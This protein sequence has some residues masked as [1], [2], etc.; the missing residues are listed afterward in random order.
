MAGRKARIRTRDGTNGRE[1]SVRR[2]ASGGRT[3]CRCRTLLAMNTARASPILPSLYF[4]TEA[5]VLFPW[6]FFSRALFCF[7]LGNSRPLPVCD[8]R[9]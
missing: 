7:L 5:D 3:R 1:N 8:T 9:D 4:R 6:L 2:Y